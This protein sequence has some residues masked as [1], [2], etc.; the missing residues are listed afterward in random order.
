ML[1]KPH[2]STPPTT[3]HHE[4][5]PPLPPTTNTPA[6][7]SQPRSSSP[8]RAASQPHAVPCTQRRLID[9]FLQPDS[10]DDVWLPPTQGTPSTQQPPQVLP[11]S[12]VPD[13][14]MTPHDTPDAASQRTKGHHPSPT[15]PAHRIRRTCTEVPGTRLVRSR[16]T[17][18][19]VLL[20]SALPHAV[21]T[22]LQA[23]LAAFGSSPCDYPLDMTHFVVPATNTLPAT[24]NL[25]V[26]LA[27]G[28][29]ALHAVPA[30]VNIMR[31]THVEHAV[32]P[33]PSNFRQAGCYAVLGDLQCG[34]ARGGRTLDGSLCV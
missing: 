12:C 20:S 8:A 1:H 2:A 31:V 28:A 13:S 9:A 25:L 3:Q 4:P 17:P 32:Q 15:T 27:A 23:K 14:Q 21:R 29:S 33:S 30:A 7:A 11:D 26:A 5:S 6:H 22:K 34:S 10:H 19:R 18:P 16:H 24:L